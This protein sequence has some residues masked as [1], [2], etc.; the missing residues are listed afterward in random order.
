VARDSVH[1]RQHALILDAASSEIAFDHLP[2]GPREGLLVLRPG[3]LHRQQHA[4]KQIRQDEE[5]RD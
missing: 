2:A 4:K 3:E 1:R 5:R